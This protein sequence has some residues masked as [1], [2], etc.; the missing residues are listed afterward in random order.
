VNIHF[1][2][3]QVSLSYKNTYTIILCYVVFLTRSY[4]DDDDADADDDD[5]DKILFFTH[6]SI[7]SDQV[8]VSIA[9]LQEAC[10]TKFESH[11][12]QL[13]ETSGAT[14][15]STDDVDV[16]LVADLQDLQDAEAETYLQTIITMVCCQ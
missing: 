14:D 9:L 6:F 5:N 8:K 11:R 10:H 2:Q 13:I 7:I 1:A 3:E 12:Q 15:I 16:M 4:L